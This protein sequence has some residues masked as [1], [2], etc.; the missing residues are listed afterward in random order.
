MHKKIKISAVISAYNEE[1]KIKRCLESLKWVDEI[2]FVDNSSVDSTVQIAKNYTDKI[3]AQKNDPGNID[4]QKNTGIEKASGDWIL[5]VDA[6]EEVSMELAD[7]IRQLNFGEIEEQINSFYIPRKNIIFG[8]WIEHSGWYP[9]WQIRLFRN[10]KGKY[11]KKHYHE[12]I[13]VEGKTCYLN[14]HIIHYNYETVAQFLHKHL[15]LYAPNE[16]DEMIS[17]G[18]VFD[19]RGIIRMPM[20]EFLSRYFAREGFRDGFHGLVLAVLM[21]FYHAGIFL[22]IWEK[23]RFNEQKGQNILGGFEEEIKKSSKEI[24]FWLNTGKVNAEKNFFRKYA[25]KIRNKLPI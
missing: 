7:E 3:I 20:S 8:K 13:S 11:N 21:A 24:K 5:L 15:F 1:K 10:G 4:I 6:D 9:D 22:N 18:Y 25:R 19:W 17:R 2:I 14:E 16:A 23:E 12:M